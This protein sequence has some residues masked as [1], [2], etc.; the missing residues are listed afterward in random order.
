[1]IDR[2]ESTS[3]ANS[4]LCVRLKTFSSLLRYTYTNIHK[5]Y[6]FFGPFSNIPIL[7]NGSISAVIS[8]WRIP[9]ASTGDQPAGL[10]ICT[11]Q[12][13]SSIRLNNLWEKKTCGNVA[14][15]EPNKPTI[16][17][18][19]KNCIVHIPAFNGSA[20]LF[21]GL[22]KCVCVC[23]FFFCWFY[24]H[25]FGVHCTPRNRVANFFTCRWLKGIDL[26]SCDLI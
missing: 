12:T 10:C 6:K 9:F 16:E 11:I 20:L 17:S 15:T 18:K 19:Y 24:C 8:T 2:F 1:M 26:L 4:D 3:I 5:R 13:A 14:E 7:F 25:C 22:R 23:M 21:Y